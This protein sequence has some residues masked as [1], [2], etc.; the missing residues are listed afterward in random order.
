M[1]KRACDCR[2]NCLIKASGG[3]LALTHY[4]ISRRFGAGGGSPVRR[5][6]ELVIRKLVGPALAAARRIVVPPSAVCWA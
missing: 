3:Q 1:R 4:T 6:L 2:P 5:A